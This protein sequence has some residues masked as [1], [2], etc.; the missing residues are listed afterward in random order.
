MHKLYMNGF[1]WGKG[2]ICDKAASVGGPSPPF[3]GVSAEKFDL[4]TEKTIEAVFVAK[5]EVISNTNHWFAF[6]ASRAQKQSPGRRSRRQPGCGDNLAS[7]PGKAM[8]GSSIMRC[9]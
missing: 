4:S 8:I 3:F 7:I 5:N 6:V 1:R 2:S 9:R